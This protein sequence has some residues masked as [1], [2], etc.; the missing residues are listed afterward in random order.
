M[1]TYSLTIEYD[2]TEYVGWQTQ[3]NGRTV[4]A[5]IE[6]AL[7]QIL[8]QPVSIIG[9]GRTDSG[10]HARGQVA[11]FRLTEEHDATALRRSLNGVL[12]SDIVIHDVRHEDD[13]FHARFNATSRRYRYTIS[14]SPLA[15]GRQYVWHVFYPLAIDR[16]QQSADEIIGEHDF[17]AFCK[18]DTEQPHYQ[19]AI[20]Q[21]TWIEEGS[22]VHF[23]IRANRFLYGMVRALVGT[24]VDVG[25]EHTSLEEFVRIV[26]GRNRQDAGMAA[27]ARGLVLEEISYGQRR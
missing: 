24:M 15:V 7:H 8:Q 11:S 25:R 23:D 20:A 18:A 2:G 5:E 13:E 16:M 3:P 22:L 1:P 10:V 12:P 4:Q 17:Q 6:T 21:A 14:R 26:K 9:G 27:P 19:C